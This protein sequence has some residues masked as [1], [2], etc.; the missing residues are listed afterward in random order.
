MD[1][2]PSFGTSSLG[3]L[4]YKIALCAHTAPSLGVEHICFTPS[5]G[6]ERFGL[7]VG[8]I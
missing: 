6:A 1:R 3:L 8:K 2:C 4:P 5:E 7:K